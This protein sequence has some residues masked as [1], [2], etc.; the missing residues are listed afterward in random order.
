[1]C[2]LRS[3]SLATRNNIAK[4][5]SVLFDDGSV[6]AFSDFDSGAFGDA[7]EEATS[8]GSASEDPSLPESLESASVTPP[9]LGGGALRGGLHHE[10]GGGGVGGRL[11]IDV[12]DA[13]AAASSLADQLAAVCCSPPRHR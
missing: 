7:T 4:Q 5:L 2:P 9:G 3:A 1:M 12:T 13:D 6:N 10:G 11:S 8:G